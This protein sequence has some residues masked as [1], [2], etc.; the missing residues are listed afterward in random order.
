LINRRKSP[1]KLK[2]SEK[3]LIGTDMPLF[4]PEPP[5]PAIFDH[6]QHVRTTPG[7]EAIL[8]VQV[9]KHAVTGDSRSPETLAGT[10]DVQ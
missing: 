10:G 7:G 4:M 8:M 5:P 1:T 9:S 2:K 3:T 6:R